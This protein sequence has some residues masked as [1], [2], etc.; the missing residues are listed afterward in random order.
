MN[1]HV[2]VSMDMYLNMY[3]L[4]VS[5]RCT[6]TYLSVHIYRH[7]CMYVYLHTLEAD[8]TDVNF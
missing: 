4:Y 7:V 2:Y 1:I 6:Y 5:H 3:V 8:P